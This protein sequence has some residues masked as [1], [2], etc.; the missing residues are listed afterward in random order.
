MSKRK[1]KK[2][3]KQINAIRR[4]TIA[5]KEREKEK[6]KNPVSEKVLKSIER[7][8]E[9]QSVRKAEKE[10]YEQMSQ[11]EKD[12]LQKVFSQLKLEFQ[13]RQRYPEKYKQ[14]DIENGK[15]PDIPA[16]FNMD[17][18]SDYVGRSQGN[19]KTKIR[20]L[21]QKKYYLENREQILAQQKEYRK[22]VKEEKQ[23]YFDEH[24]EK[25]EA[26]RQI[27]NNYLS[28]LQT[29]KR[30]IRKPQESYMN[31][32][33]RI[34]L[35]PEST[36]PILNSNNQKI[37]IDFDKVLEQLEQI[38][39]AKR[40][41]TMER[42]KH[43]QRAWELDLPVKDYID[44]IKRIDAKKAQEERREQSLKD[45]L[46]T[47]LSDEELKER[48]EIHQRLEELN[49]IVPRFIPNTDKDD[50]YEYVI[51]EIKNEMAKISFDKGK[52]FLDILND[53]DNLIILNKI[54]KMKVWE[55]VVNHFDTDTMLQALEHMSA[56]E[57]K[58]CTQG[59][60]AENRMLY[61]GK[62]LLEA[63]TDLVL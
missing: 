28:A 38:R 58:M 23:Q 16:M 56:N 49:K 53:R 25:R 37:E 36:H 6:E 42:K 59:N 34:L 29:R 24:P 3:L 44:E 40:H 45:F 22:K 41:F 62:Y 30:N 48:Q 19:V 15:N 26:R 51:K 63:N 11:E 39:I 2:R 60:K 14:I 52:T 61:L 27:K 32:Y 55:N 9:M 8:Q 35:A 33:W 17:R 4:K 46:I 7:A 1:T 47:N 10:A 50:S 21:R 12:E 13:L 57:R 31:I 18:W 43:L 5:K 54:S 20:K